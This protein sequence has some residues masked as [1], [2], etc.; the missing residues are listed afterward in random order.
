MKTMA[1]KKLPD[2][3]LNLV[4]G[5]LERLEQKL[6]AALHVWR[7]ASDM[8]WLA[9]KQ[10][11]LG[12]AR[13]H[14]ALVEMRGVVE[15]LRECGD[16][17][18]DEANALVSRLAKAEKDVRE[19]ARLSGERWRKAVKGRRTPVR[20]LDALAEVRRELMD[21]IMF[22]GSA[23]AELEHWV[24]REPYLHGDDEVDDLDLEAEDW[25]RAVDDAVRHLRRWA[26][27]GKRAPKGCRLL[28]VLIDECALGLADVRAEVERARMVTKDAKGA[29]EIRDFLERLP[30]RHR[31]A[32]VGVN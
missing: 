31:V 18:V 8:G 21:C 6:P 22:C 4:H 7:D 11:E 17:E 23:Q 30:G 16:L 24:T 1:V 9:A 5:E 29:Q 12:F 32:R 19:V 25:Q 15:A 14:G 13:R 26:P 10:A 28:E 27:P 3:F 20:Q 2:P